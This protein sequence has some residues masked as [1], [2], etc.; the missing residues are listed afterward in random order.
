MYKFIK[1]I[2]IKT[3]FAPTLK[4]LRFDLIK[5]KARISTRIMFNFYKRK[6][7]YIPEKMHFG[8]GKRKIEDWLNVDLKDS[9][10]NIDFSTGKLPFK[11]GQFQYIV[12]Q[13]IIEHF[14]LHTECEPI[15]KELYRVL[16]DNGFLY[17]SCPSIQKICDSYIKDK[18]ETLIK[19]KKKRYPNYKIE[20]YPS[21]KVVNEI[22]YQS[23]EHKNL[24]D[25]DLI[26]YVLKNI[27][28]KNVIQIQEK[29]LLQKFKEFPIRNDDEQSLYVFA[30]K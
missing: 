7:I 3:A 19:G 6:N 10:I 24:F 25:F 1:K 9:D 27:G 28:F 30:S 18:G 21:S 26:Y 22:F 12:S 23:G 15:L 8:C 11:D 16:K 20:G 4:A 5:L 29:D 2:L 17:L 13:H 14:E